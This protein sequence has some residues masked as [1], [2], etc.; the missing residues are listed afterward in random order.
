MPTWLTDLQGIGAILSGIAAIIA[1][2]YARSASKEMKP[3]HGTSMRDLI[4]VMDDRIKSLGH[5]QG[6]L[7]DDIQS[8]MQDARDDHTRLWKELEKIQR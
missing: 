6:E 4:D 1:A 8:F 5:R 3:D 2:V 7:H